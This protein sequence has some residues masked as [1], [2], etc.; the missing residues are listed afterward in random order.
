ML[1]IFIIFHMIIIVEL[2]FKFSYTRRKVLSHI[3][4]S[5]LSM[6]CVSTAIKRGQPSDA[7][8]PLF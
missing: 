1:F 7:A 4:P 8:Q 3:A 2:M 6:E 5:F